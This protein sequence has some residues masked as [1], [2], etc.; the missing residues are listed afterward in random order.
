MLKL[1]AKGGAPPVHYLWN[2]GSL[3]APAT[4]HAI[5]AFIRRRSVRLVVIDSL[6]AA[7]PGVDQNDP[8]FAEPLAA[9]A[10][11]AEETGC[12]FLVLHH[13]KKGNGPSNEVVRGTTAIFAAC[14]AIY[15]TVDFKIPDPDTRTFTLTTLK[16]GPGKLPPP[17]HLRL[18]DAGGL[19]LDA[20]G[21]AGEAEGQ[22][23]TE[24]IKGAM[25]DGLGDAQ[26]IGQ[27]LRVSR[28][29]VSPELKQMCA[30]GEARKDGR[31]YLLD[32]EG[33]RLGRI[34][35]AMSRGT[36]APKDLARLAAV[37]TDD[38]TALERKGFLR[39]AAGGYTLG[40]QAPP[41][42]DSWR[43]GVSPSEA[44]D[45]QSWLEAVGGG[46]DIA[47]DIADAG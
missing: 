36:Y 17:V 37:Q 11:I 29:I 19:Q 26:A 7:N 23:L 18:S 38:L 33:A 8:R 47:A 28:N 32:G 42:P 27:Y 34:Y 10:K 43:Q 39:R 30:A 2:P 24:R 22:T 16:P 45:V 25:R 31:R 46:A 41:F 15:R 35:L 12:S 40:V 21:T 3:A 44:E 20:D 14:D 5:E 9:A 6:S 13:E 4:W 1:L